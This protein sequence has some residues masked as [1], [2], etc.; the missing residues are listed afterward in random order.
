MEMKK[1]ESSNIDMIGWDQGVAPSFGMRPKSVLR[2]IFK[3]GRKYDYYNV[4]KETFDKML[5]AKSVGKFFHEH[6]NKKYNYELV[7]V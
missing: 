7:N 1:V 4:S 6:I 3:N 2:I 5:E